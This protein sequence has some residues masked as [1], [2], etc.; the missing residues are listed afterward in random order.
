MVS[1]P[2]RQL[3]VFSDAV[4]VDERTLNV[5]ADHEWGVPGHARQKVI[6]YVDDIQVYSKT[7]EDHLRDLEEVFRRLQHNCLITK[8]LL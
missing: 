1:H 4:R 7:R 3:R 6:V 5:P 8:G 2:L